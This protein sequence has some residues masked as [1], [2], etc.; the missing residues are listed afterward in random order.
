MYAGTTIRRVAS[1]RVT[2]TRNTALVA[3][4]KWWLVEGR[5]VEPPLLHHL[6]EYSESW[7]SLRFLF[8]K[9]SLCILTSILLTKKIIDT[10][11]VLG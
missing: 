6:N 5:R 10:D 7:L 2:R 1:P 11:K 4:E 3:R 8:V 9:V